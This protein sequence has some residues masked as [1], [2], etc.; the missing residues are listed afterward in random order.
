MR[1]ELKP[2]KGDG[3]IGDEARQAMKEERERILR[4]AR[5]TMQ[6]ATRHATCNAACNM[7]RGVQHATRHATCNAACNMRCVDSAS[8]F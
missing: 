4:S 7:Q 3:E 6:H 8:A 5:H 2:I 1:R